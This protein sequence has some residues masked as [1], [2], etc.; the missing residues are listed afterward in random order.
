MT[1]PDR[2]RR[3]RAI[4]KQRRIHRELVENMGALGRAAGMAAKNIRF[5]IASA[6]HFADVNAPT[7]R[8]INTMRRVG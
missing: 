5:F 7:M 8:E 2:R 3:G 6:S 4:R 1:H